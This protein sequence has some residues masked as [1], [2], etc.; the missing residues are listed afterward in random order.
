[1]SGVSASADSRDWQSVRMLRLTLGQRIVAV[2][3]LG[4]TLA[5]IA[6]FIVNEAW[7]AGSGFPINAF[8]PSNGGQIG[9]AA[10]Y[11]FGG[12]LSGWATFL[13]W[14]GAVALWSAGALFLLKR[15]TVAH[16]SEGEHGEAST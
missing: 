10:L 16:C 9:Q 13:V 14:I 6:N 15:P 1:M 8:V 5:L 7:Q 11:A 12:G 2:I 3:A 4:L